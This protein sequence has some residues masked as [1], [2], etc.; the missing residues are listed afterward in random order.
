MSIANFRRYFLALRPDRRAATAIGRAR[1]AVGPFRAVVTDDRLHTT[2]G[3]LAEVPHQDE[4]VAACAKR[5]LGNHLFEAFPFA[6]RRL[7][8]D[9]GIG[10]LLPA[11]RQAGIRSLQRGLFERF[12][13]YGIELKNPKNFRPHVTL[14]YGPCARDRR[15]IRPIGWFADQIVLI[16]SWVG[17]G[18][19]RTLDCW[20]LLPP[21]QGQFDFG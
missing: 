11:G 4:R 9:E 10:M 16:E 7:V 5:A 18:I 14:G 6:L 13:G 2:I 15:D 20:P 12:G 17:R 8:L 3:I 1:D 21:A 19:H